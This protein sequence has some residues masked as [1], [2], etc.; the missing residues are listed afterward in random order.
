MGNNQLRPYPVYTGAKERQHL[1]R[2]SGIDIT[3]YCD[4]AAYASTDGS[5]YFGGTNGVL[6][7]ECNAVQ[8]DSIM[9]PV[10]FNTITAGNIEHNIDPTSQLEFS[11]RDNTFSIGF[12]A[13]DY[14]RGHDFQYSYRLLGASDKWV[15]NG[16]SERIS[17][18]NLPSGNYRLQVRYRHGATQ[19]GIYELPL[20]ITPPWYA[21]P[22]AFTVYILLIIALFIG[23]IAVLMRNQR[24]KRHRIV[25]DMEHQ[26]RE[27]IYESKLR[28]FTNIT[29]ELCT[30]LNLIS[31][32]CQR[33]LDNKNLDA[34]TQRF[35]SLIH[36]NSRRLNELIQE[37]IEFRRIDTDHRKP[38]V[39]QT[40]VSTLT[41]EIADNFRIIAVR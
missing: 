8:T 6:A 11:Y 41:A 1:Q 4:G 21:S 2:Q 24:R 20:R 9:P 27:D 10:R 30:P 36:R 3:S 31:G 5:C 29:H 23:I 18:T 32:S 33:M 15:D 28:F 13:V 7:V 34:S 25:K 22:W 19:S 17:F 39:T 35:T 14:W 37:L 16:N 40:D 38:D 12:D 26:Q